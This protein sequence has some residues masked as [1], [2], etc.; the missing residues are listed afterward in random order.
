[1][2]DDNQIKWYSLIEIMLLYSKKLGK[3]IVGIKH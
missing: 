1:M 3:D 2:F